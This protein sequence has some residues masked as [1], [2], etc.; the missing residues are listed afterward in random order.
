MRTV[1]RPYADHDTGRMRT[2]SLASGCSFPLRRARSSYMAWP[3][4][5]A[6]GHNLRVP[7]RSVECSP[8][9]LMVCVT[10]VQSGGMLTLHVIVT[11]CPT[12]IGFGAMAMDPFT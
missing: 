9:P 2:A 1:V 11:G 8:G 6:V 5:A 4:A 10:P 3:F 12:W 7:E